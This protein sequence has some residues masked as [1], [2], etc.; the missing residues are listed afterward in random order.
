[1]GEHSSFKPEDPNNSQISKSKARR[2]LMQQGPGLFD[3]QEKGKLEIEEK[4]EA[5]LE[6]AE[7]KQSELEPRKL[8]F[9]EGTRLYKFLKDSEGKPIIPRDLAQEEDLFDRQL[10][11]AT[12][13][14]VPVDYLEIGEKGKTVTKKVGQSRFGAFT[15]VLSPVRQRNGEVVLEKRLASYLTRSS[16]KKL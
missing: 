3:E 1:M 7:A 10:T 8:K 2:P 13:L 6:I 12:Y 9:K 14:D 16:R 11:V 4:V 5:K 15:V